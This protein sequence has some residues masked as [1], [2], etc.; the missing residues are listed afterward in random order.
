MIIN[1]AT[2]VARLTK[3]EREHLDESAGIVDALFKLGLIGSP[4]ISNAREFAAKGE[5]EKDEG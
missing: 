2:G 1:H 4:T 5:S 3:K